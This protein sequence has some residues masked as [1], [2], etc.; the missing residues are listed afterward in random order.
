[1]NAFIRFGRW[2]DKRNLRERLDVL[3]GQVAAIRTDL[4]ALAT[5]SAESP[6]LRTI[7]DRLTKVEM[8]T[9]VKKAAAMKDPKTIMEFW[10]A[11]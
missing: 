2:L 1:M 9:N 6:E 11:H 4:A 5:T 8:F 3:E 7:K 10:N